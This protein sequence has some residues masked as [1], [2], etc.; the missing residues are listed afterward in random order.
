MDNILLDIK[1]KA[2]FFTTANFHFKKYKKNSIILAVYTVALIYIF[3]AFEIEYYSRG[4]VRDHVKF[5]LL[6][7]VIIYIFLVIGNLIVIKKTEAIG[8]EYEISFFENRLEM[9]HLDFFKKPYE[10]IVY[11]RD[12]KKLKETKTRIYLIG[13]DI[14]CIKKDSALESELKSLRYIIDKIKLRMKNS[15]IHDEMPPLSIPR[16]DETLEVNVKIKRLVYSEKILFYFAAAYLTSIVTAYSFFYG[17]YGLLVKENIIITIILYIVL[18]SLVGG[19]FVSFIYYIVYAIIYFI[20]VKKYKFMN[21]KFLE[22]HMEIIY[23]N[24]ETQDKYSF[25]YNYLDIKEETRTC[26]KYR[27]KNNV[28]VEHFIY[29]KRLTSEEIQ[30]IR[31]INESILYLESNKKF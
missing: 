28:N 23:S 25:W 12:I 21:V 1:N 11:Y 27:N 14:V 19:F 7:P 9:I 16:V 10:Q 30:L 3:V 2:S 15:Y 29:K 18:S 22:D 24:E 17:L 31:H 5:W 13:K 4:F 6:T 8:K 20:K 26:F